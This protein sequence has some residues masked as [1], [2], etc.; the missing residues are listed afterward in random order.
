MGKHGD[1]AIR[2]CSLLIGALAMTAVFATATSDKPS[3]ALQN[4]PPWRDSSPHKGYT[5]K[6]PVESLQD[7]AV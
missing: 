1:M 3:L 5:V 6:T 7:G 2:C 4:T